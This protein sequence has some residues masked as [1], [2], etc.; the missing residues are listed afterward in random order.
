MN[1]TKTSIC[2]IPLDAWANIM[3]F[4]DERNLTIT[5]DILYSSG[6]FG[7]EESERLNTFWILVSLAKLH[8]QAMNSRTSFIETN[9]EHA[10]TF[11][12]LCEMGLHKEK[13][14]SIIRQ[15]DGTL[16]HAFQILGW[17]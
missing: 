16:H 5:F 3:L 9:N 17:S 10:Q 6:V 1:L 15:T 12:K 8:H 2:D 4:V 7:V 11:A 14:A 13:A